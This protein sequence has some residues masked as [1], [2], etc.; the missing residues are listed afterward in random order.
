MQ[1]Q[2]SGTSPVGKKFCFIF[3]SCAFKSLLRPLWMECSWRTF[4]VYV[5]RVLYVDSSDDG[6]RGGRVSS[7]TAYNRRRLPRASATVCKLKSETACLRRRSATAAE[8]VGAASNHAS[9]T[10]TN[11]TRSEVTVALAH[12]YNI[13]THTDSRRDAAALPHGNLHRNAISSGRAYSGGVFWIRIR[14]PGQPHGK[15]SYKSWLRFHYTR[16]AS[17]SVTVL[18]AQ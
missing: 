5:N 4:D 18:P 12:T 14:G 15:Q 11:A 8:P 16:S 2:R 10:E 17:G 13:N 3:G 6:D 9:N 1:R 7:V